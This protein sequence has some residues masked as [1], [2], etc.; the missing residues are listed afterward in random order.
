VAASIP[1][2]A[3]VELPVRVSIPLHSAFNNN[4][5]PAGFL[6][7]TGGPGTSLGL[8]VQV[9][10]VPVGATITSIEARVRDSAIGPTRVSLGFADQ[11]DNGFQQPAVRPGVASSGAGAP[12]FQTIALTGIDRVVQPLHVYYAGVFLVSGSQPVAVSA[13]DVIYLPPP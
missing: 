11:L 10:M 5:I 9:P 3:V 2:L 8:V 6:S 1:E 4:V 13:I 7:T 12:D